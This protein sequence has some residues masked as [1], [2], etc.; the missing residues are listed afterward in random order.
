MLVGFAAASLFLTEP[1]LRDSRLIRIGGALVIGFVLLRALNVYGD[2]RAWQ[3]Y[4]G[5]LT[6]S[7]QSFLATTKYPPS[8]LYTPCSACPRAMQPINSSLTTA[9]TPKDLGLASGAGM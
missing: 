9:S 3:S 1:K 6:G 7:V 2:P 8:L 5:N 4:P